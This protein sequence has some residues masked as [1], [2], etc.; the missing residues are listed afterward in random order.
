M[1]SDGLQE[2]ESS[3]SDDIGGVVRDLEGDGDVRLSSKVVD[4]VWLD[5]VEPTAE[6][7]GI[8]EIGVVELHASFVDIVGIDVDMVDSLSVEI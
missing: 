1:R 6:G 2:A 3:S 4:L 7:G 5:D 8:R